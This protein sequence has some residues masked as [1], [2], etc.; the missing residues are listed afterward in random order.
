MR[1]RNPCQALSMASNVQYMAAC[2]TAPMREWFSG[3]LDSEMG[4]QR[5]PLYKLVCCVFPTGF[6]FRRGSLNLIGLFMHIAI[7]CLLLGTRRCRRCDMMK[8]MRNAWVEEAGPH[9]D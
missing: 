7:F 2:K 3:I 4:I 1:M 9:Q 5:E 6:A 8:E